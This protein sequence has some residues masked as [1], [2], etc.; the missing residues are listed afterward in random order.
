[1][2]TTPFDSDQPNR[3]LPLPGVEMHI[4][5]DHALY[6]QHPY[7][8]EGYL[9]RHGELLPVAN[10][11]YNTG[12]VARLLADGRFELLGR[13]SDSVNRAGF[14]VQFSDIENALLRTG[15]V[16]QAVVLCSNEETWRGPKLYAFCIP[17]AGKIVTAQTIREA[18]FAHLPRYAVPDEVLLETTF[19]RSATDKIDRRRLQQKITELN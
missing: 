18:C 10:N 11:P 1:V 6:C 13:Q 12:D 8:F 5:D 2:A 9:N 15:E 3:L 17:V 4:R 7:G 14:L 19:P 16:E